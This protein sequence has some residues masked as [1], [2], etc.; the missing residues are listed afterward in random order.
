[1]LRKSII[2]WKY[3]PVET[4]WGQIGAGDTFSL[5]GAGLTEEGQGG[6]LPSAHYQWPP[7]APTWLMHHS[8]LVA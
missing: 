6:L 8:G 2:P 4:V 3:T 1:M 5:R 7:S